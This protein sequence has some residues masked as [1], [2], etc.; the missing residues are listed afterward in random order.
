MQNQWRD[1]LLLGGCGVVSVAVA[2]RPE[3]ERSER[4][5]N[6]TNDGDPEISAP[7]E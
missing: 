7:T 3:V 1:G 2:A 6:Q 4:D 5:D